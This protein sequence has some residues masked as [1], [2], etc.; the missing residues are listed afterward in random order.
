MTEESHFLGIFQTAQ[1]EKIPLEVSVELTHHC[2]FR[3]I[4]CYIPDFHAPDQ[5][6]TD[7]VLKLLDELVEMGRSTSPSRA[8]RFF[9][10]RTGVRFFGQPDKGDSRSPSSRTAP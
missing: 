4:H 2:N 3:C 10:G 5:L 7:R 6:S 1:R 8:V 9:S